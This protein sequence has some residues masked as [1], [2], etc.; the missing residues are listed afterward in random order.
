[1][2]TLTMVM[3]REG[4]KIAVEKTG[5]GLALVIVDGVRCSRAFGPSEATAV[6][7]GGDS[8]QRPGGIGSVAAQRVPQISQNYPTCDFQRFGVRSLRPLAYAGPDW[9]AWLACRVLLA[10][11]ALRP[12]RSGWPS[13]AGGSGSDSRT[14]R[15]H[16]AGAIEMLGRLL[17]EVG[18]AASLQRFV[19]AA[20]IIGDEHET[21]QRTQW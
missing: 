11:L 7:L 18:D 4:T 19:E 13:P 20:R 3:S 15:E 1:M 12:S 9:P 10:G 8:C 17:G 21:A 6:A 5:T 16:H 14:D 2:N